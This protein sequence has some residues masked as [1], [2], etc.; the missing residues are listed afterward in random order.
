MARETLGTERGST[1]RIK[2]D[3]GDRADV[4]SLRY[5]QSH[6]EGIRDGD[7][8]EDD[9]DDDGDDDDDDDDYDGDDDDDDDDGDDDDDD[10]GD[11]DNRRADS[12]S[13]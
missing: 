11:E 1:L 12:W 8:G 13:D 6:T 7:D 2:H 9:D 5:S 4:Q 3:E 10:G